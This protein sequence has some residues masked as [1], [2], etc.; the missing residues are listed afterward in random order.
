VIIAELPPI[1]GKYFYNP[2]GE[3]S[4]PLFAALMK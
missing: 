3:I 2:K 4:E 1:S